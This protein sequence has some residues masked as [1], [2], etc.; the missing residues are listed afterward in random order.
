[1]CGGEILS[2]L[3]DFVAV[4]ALQR[5]DLQGERADDRARGVRVDWRNRDGRSLLLLAEVRDS[6]LELSVAVEEGRRAW[7]VLGDG[8]EGDRTSFFDQLTDG[9]LGALDG[10]VVLACRGCAQDF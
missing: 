8:F 6:S 7:G 10:V 9:P 3:R 1:V 5:G 4:A 2:Q